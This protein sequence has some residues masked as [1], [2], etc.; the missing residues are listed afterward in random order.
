MSG[1][2]WQLFRQSI[3]TQSHPERADSVCPHLGYPDLSRRELKADIHG[4]LCHF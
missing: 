3:D 2:N 4:G 1:R